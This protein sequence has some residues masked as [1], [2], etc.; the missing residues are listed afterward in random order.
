VR[1]AAD[2]FLT[3]A[4]DGDSSGED[5]RSLPRRALALL[6]VALLAVSAPLF[7]TSP[8]QGGDGPGAAL[9]KPVA[10]ASDEEEDDVS[11]GGDDDQG[12]ADETMGNTDAGG[13]DTGMSTVGETDGQD[14]TGQ[15]ERTE[16]TGVETQGQ[17]D[18][19][20][21]ATGVSTRGETD[22]QDDTGQTERR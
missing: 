15:T 7:W 22:G 13:Q 3:L 2:V 16:G 5:Q 10:A 9:V 6:V 4:S 20:G 1:A 21:Q 17:T 18:P 19:G 11:G 8:A 12:T 14:N